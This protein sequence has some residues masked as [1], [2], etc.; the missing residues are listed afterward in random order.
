MSFP[1]QNIELLKF[2]E[3]GNSEKKAAEKFKVGRST[4]KRIKYKKDDLHW[5]FEI[6]CYRSDRCRKHSKTEYEKL[7]EIRVCFKFNRN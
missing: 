3:A 5:Q 2:L 1:C 7:N 4:V 6:E